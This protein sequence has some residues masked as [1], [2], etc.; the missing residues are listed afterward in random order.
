MENMKSI[1][2]KNCYTLIDRNR[3]EYDDMMVK[4]DTFLI[5]DRISSDEYNIL[6]S[7]MN[8]KKPTV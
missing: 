8:D 4:L 6:V 1:T 3:Y 2:A 7:M 5:N